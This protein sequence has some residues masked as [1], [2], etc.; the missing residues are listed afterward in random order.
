MYFLVNA[1]FRLCMCNCNVVKRVLDKISYDLDPKVKIK[2]N[3]VG[4]CDR[5]EERFP[6]YKLRLEKI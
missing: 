6:S 2:G 1:S 4:I 3:T 5:I